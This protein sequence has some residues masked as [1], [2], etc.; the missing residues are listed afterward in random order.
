MAAASDP[1]TATLFKRRRRPGAPTAPAAS[2]WPTVDWWRGF[3]SPQLDDYM[4]QAQ[5]GNDDIA[6]A[7]ARVLE[8]D[9]QARIA[10]AALLPAVDW[11]Q[12]PRGSACSTR[13]EA[14]PGSADIY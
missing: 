1:S 2:D 9:A 11:A 7:I 14:G 5:V 13:P 10:G 3:G 4:G 12:R 6:A 8:A